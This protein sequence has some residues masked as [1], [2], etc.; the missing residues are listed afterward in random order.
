MLQYNVDVIMTTTIVF[1][2]SNILL[3]QR[4]YV[5]ISEISG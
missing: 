4:G 2:I 3:G 1:F 5:Q